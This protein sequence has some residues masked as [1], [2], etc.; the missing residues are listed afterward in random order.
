M[1]LYVIMG[2]NRCFDW[3]DAK[4]CP[5]TQDFSWQVVQWGE[6]WGIEFLQT[7]RAWITMK[8]CLPPSQGQMVTIGGKSRIFSYAGRESPFFAGIGIA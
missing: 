5:V 3:S 2:V 6:V 4:I 8:K 1:S 7:P